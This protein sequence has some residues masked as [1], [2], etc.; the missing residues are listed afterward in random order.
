MKELL[1]PSQRIEAENNNEK[2]VECPKFAAFSLSSYA[3]HDI[4]RCIQRT[5]YIGKLSWEYTPKA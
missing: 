5:I 3:I 2:L 1:F 4:L